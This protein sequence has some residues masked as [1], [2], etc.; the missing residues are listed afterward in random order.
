MKKGRFI[1]FDGLDGAGKDTM[2]E[3]LRKD[4]EANKVNYVI[5]QDPS[6]EVAKEIRE[7]L[8]SKEEIEDSTRIYLYL[9]AR[10]ELIYKQILPALRAR[11]LVICNRFSLSTYAYQGLHFSKE[12]IEMLHKLGRLDIVKP[13]RQIILLS[14]KSYREKELED[15]MGEYC[16]NFR[17]E[18][19]D[20][21]I[22][23]A[24]EPNTGVVW[25]DNKT[26]SQVYD[27]VKRYCF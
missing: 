20:R 13:D 26:I 4:L 17:K 16:N 11:K 14:E 9:A 25:T 23:L 19:A 27:E 6:P 8:L 24:R 5:F 1:V 22:E 10:S 3:E 2:I 21:Y 12:D 7:I 18:I 15:V